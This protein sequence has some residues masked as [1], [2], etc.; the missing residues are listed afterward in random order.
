MNI[1]RDVITDLWPLYD[2]GEA[3]EDTRQLVEQFLDDD[4]EFGRLIHESTKE[5]IRT[6]GLPPLSREREVE[7][8]RKT[9]RLLRIRDSL[10]WIAIFLTF[11]PLTVYNTSWG[12]GW[13]IR[14]HPFLAFALASAAAM[15]WCFYFMLKRRL[16]VTGL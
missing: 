6:D 2:S 10:L 14:D 8:L 16:S 13:V 5:S 7:T 11:T 9:K 15:V 12:S 1:T 3:S 4:Q